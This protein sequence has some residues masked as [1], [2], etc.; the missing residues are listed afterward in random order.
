MLVTTE[1][2]IRHYLTESK[3]LPYA[4]LRVPNKAMLTGKE[5]GDALKVAIEKKDVTKVAVADYFGVKPP[6]V[7]DWIKFGRIGKQHLNNLVAYFA[8]VVP[9]SHWGMADAIFQNQ[10]GS[11]TVVQAKSEGHAFPDASTQSKDVQ[12]SLVDRSQILAN[13]IV[14]ATR[15]GLLNEDGIA[16][17]ERNMRA[18]VAATSDPV[19]L[20]GKGSELRAPPGEVKNARR[21]SGRGSR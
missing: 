11:Y 21:A 6:S 9:P 18:C 5:L 3:A 8:D 20:R 10:D 13:Q 14:S 4:R 16:Q 19:E 7:Q 15:S 2:R 12:T 1:G 17:L